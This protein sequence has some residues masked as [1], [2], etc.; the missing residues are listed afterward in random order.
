MAAKVNVSLKIDTFMQEN[1]EELK[2]IKGKVRQERGDNVEIEI[3]YVKALDKCVVL[4][5]P[6]V[7]EVTRFLKELRDD[8]QSFAAQ[9]NLVISATV[10]PNKETMQKYIEMRPLIAVGL[11]N[12][13]SEM[14]GREMEM[15][16]K[17]L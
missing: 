2:V 3:V 15:T 16:S 4:A 7:D 10:Y 11:A 8:D 17:K 5:T 12:K 1:A 13:A 6:D 9:Q 14:S